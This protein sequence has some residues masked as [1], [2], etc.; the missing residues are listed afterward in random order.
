MAQREE[1][2]YADLDEKAGKPT[3]W[4]MVLNEQVKVINRLMT[5]ND[6][7]FP[8]AVEAFKSDLVFFTDKD[9]RYAEELS[10]IDNEAKQWLENTKSFDGRPDWN[11]TERVAYARAKMIFEA[12]LRAMGRAGF[13]PQRRV[14]FKE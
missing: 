4:Q 2:F 8:T 3:D 9:K 6:V 1:S 13:Y 10:N 11:E 14:D 5:F 7:S 12:C